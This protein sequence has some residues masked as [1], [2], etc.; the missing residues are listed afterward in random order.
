M[1]PFRNNQEPSKK[2]V[3]SHP[4]PRVLSRWME[5]ARILGRPRGE[6]RKHLTTK[7]EQNDLILDG[8]LAASV[9]SPGKE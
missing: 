6:E 8:D 1:L 2:W 7:G 3:F 4:V 9:T 5:S